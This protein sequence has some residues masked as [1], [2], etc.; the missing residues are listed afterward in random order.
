MESS[1]VVAFRALIMVA[2]LVLV[3]LAAIFG[4]A[5]PEV[6]KANLVDRFWP[7]RKQQVAHNAAEAP[8]FGD[9]SSFNQN[10]ANGSRAAA[11]EA[12][13]AWPTGG[14]NSPS[15]VRAVG[16]ERGGEITRATPAQFSAPA[17]SSPPAWPP[18]GNGHLATQKA[19]G[20]DAAMQNQNAPSDR[21]APTRR[22]ASGN[23]L[24][25][26]ERLTP[27]QR[28]VPAGRAAFEDRTANQAS[29]DLPVRQI[30]Y[31]AEPD[32]ERPSAYT[33]VIEN[34]LAADTS[35]QRDAPAGRPAAVQSADFKATERRLR[36]YGAAYYRLETVGKNGLE[37]RFFC[38]MPTSGGVQNPRHF[39]A[40]DS[41]PLVAMTRVADDVQA[42]LDRR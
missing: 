37:Y 13:P 29:E 30:P 39:E 18:A 42:W 26:S 34:P 17:E 33:R 4:S 41:D 31:A 9:S 32:Q 3:P 19:E 23:P 15:T 11:H 25:S 14:G 6:V 2:C 10:V 36:Q 21:P 35:S 20:L 22:L 16:S 40:V 12:A 28:Q 5:F 7:G 27:A 8:R 1:A 38:M 24:A